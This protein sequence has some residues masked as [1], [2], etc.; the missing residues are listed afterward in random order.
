VFNNDKKQ[1]INILQQNK[2]LKINYKIIQENNIIKEEQSSFLLTDDTLPNDAQFKINSLQK[3][4][5]KTYIATL[6]ENQNQQI[7]KPEEVHVISHDSI[8]IANNLKI[9]SPK[10][11][12]HSIKRYYE[13]TGLDFII[14]PYTIIEEYLKDNGKKNSLNFFIYN[15]TI[16]TIIFDKIKNISFS[17]I[18]VLTPFESTQDETFLE[19]DIVGQ[20]LYEEVNFLEIQQFLDETVEEYYGSGD[21]VDFI[22]N[23][24]MLYSLKPISDEQITTIQDA[25]MI[26]I[27]YKAISVDR[28]IDEIVQ[29]PNSTIYNFISPRIKK[30]NK[31]PYIWIGLIVAIIL[32]LSS[33]FTFDVIEKEE[34][35]KPKKIEVTQPKNVIA[36]KE[37]QI[38]PVQPMTIELPSHKNNNILMIENIQM[39]FEVLPYDAVLKDIEINK[40]SS[41]FVSNF[42]V[43][44]DSL[45]DM[46]TKLRNI[47]LNS[48]ILLQNQNKVILN[49][50][51]Q[52]DNIL[53]KPILKNIE[54]KQ[55]KFLSLSQAT[56]YLTSL[57]IPN[58]VIRFNNKS[59][60]KYFTYSFSL[61]SKIK[62]PEEF[63]TFIKKLNMQKLSVEVNYP[64]IFSKT[65]NN[66]EVR[67]NININQQNKKGVSL[68]K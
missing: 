52:N 17:K 56:D 47:Y 26:P 6:Y 54:Y 33:I 43:N 25:L 18:K 65:T 44:S 14:S 5:D 29:E 46:Q 10:N 2:Q 35:Q 20:K 50:I 4:I 61:V 13:G 1:Y 31:S 24:E 11:E 9:I 16:Y 51:I 23:I 3:D 21:N 41:T 27:S 34:E 55:F 60:E 30:E 67:Y 45:S 7:V 22:E 28:Y 36:K 15:N 49:T 40:N 58:S 37:V 19:D 64:I 38:K 32:L 42:I 53:E 39:L 8:N 66:I 48:K 68:K 62:S 63:I 57:A 59:K 12:I